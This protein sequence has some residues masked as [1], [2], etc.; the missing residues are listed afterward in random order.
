MFDWAGMHT[1]VAMAAGSRGSC[2]ATL[3]PLPVP[4][5]A[6]QA[7]SAVGPAEPGCLPGARGRPP[8]PGELSQEAD[9]FNYRVHVALPGL[10]LASKQAQ[11][12]P[13]RQLCPGRSEPAAA[14]AP[15]LGQIDGKRGE[16][17]AFRRD[18]LKAGLAASA[19]PVSGLEAEVER[20]SLI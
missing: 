7:G 4:L 17:E 12:C 16:L 13:R 20:I 14:A 3:R 1:Y 10:V 15:L 6:G 2:Q 9:G 19:A 8:Q 18:M 5:P 11:G